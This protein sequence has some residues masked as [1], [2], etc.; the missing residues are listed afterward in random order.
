MT[1][2]EARKKI[3][4]RRIQETTDRL[5]AACLQFL[6]AKEEHFLVTIR[7]LSQQLLDYGYES[8]FEH[9]RRALLVR[10]MFAQLSSQLA[11]EEDDR[12]LPRREDLPNVD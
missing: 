1:E 2:N 7:D 4:E 8:N 5:F 10:L 11:P 12:L 3:E 6:I 9:K